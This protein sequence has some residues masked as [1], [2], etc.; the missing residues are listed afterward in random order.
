MPD[1]PFDYSTVRTLTTQLHFPEGPIA[2]D[3]GSVL[4]SEI[5]GR[6]LARVD[7]DG[8]VH[9]IDC[10]GGPNGAAIGPDGAVYVDNDGGLE[11]AP[12]GDDGTM[13]PVGA[14]PENQGGFLQRVDLD[15]ETVETVFT[16]VGDQRLGNLNDIVFD[17][18]GCCYIV[19]T[20][21]DVTHGAILYADPI[22]GWIRVI[23]RGLSLPNGMGLSP[24]GT[25]LYVSESYTGNIFAW[26]VTGPGEIADKTLLFSDG[27]EHGWDGLAIDGAGNVC[28]SNLKASGVSVVT[29]EGEEIARFVTPLHDPAVTNICFGGPEGDTAYVCSSGRGIL[30]SVRWPWGGLRL[31][32]AR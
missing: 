32:Y 14:L 31:N 16:H 24:D 6:A 27:G 11:I 13:Y 30:Y 23:E 10:G 7:P 4:I 9:R 3:N 18:T 21:L 20:S 5:G 25:C 8:G 12:V 2:L 1:D 26:D 15:T 28:A 17:T 22:A 29:P 19:D